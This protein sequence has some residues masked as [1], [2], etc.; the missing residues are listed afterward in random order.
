MSFPFTFILPTLPGM[1]LPCSVS[2]IIYLKSSATASASSIC[3]M[4]VNVTILLQSNI[5]NLVL[6]L[7]VCF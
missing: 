5:P 4:S 1:K 3:F 2:L 6:S 7:L